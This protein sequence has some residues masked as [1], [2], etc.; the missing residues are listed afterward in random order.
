VISSGCKINLGLQITGRRPDGYHELRTVFYPLDHP[1]DELEFEK[2]AVP[3][4]EIVC[5]DPEIRP[6]KN[7]IF[8]AWQAFGAFCRPNFGIRATLR[9]GIPK[10]A[11]LGGGSGDAAAFLLWLNEAC[12]QPLDAAR[13]NEAALFAGA[14]VPFFLTP[15]PSLASGA[16][17]FTE[18]VR[19]MGEGLFI[20]LVCPPFGVST[21]WAFAR[22]DELREKTSPE[23]CLTNIFDKDKGNS[24]SC[25]ALKNCL[26]DCGLQNDLEAA[27]FP[28]YPELAEIKNALLRL[29]ALAAGMSGSGSSI[30]GIF[31]DEGA[32]KQVK[33]AM[34]NAGRLYFS[35][36]RNYC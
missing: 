19:F 36:M 33:E 5:D 29:G 8:R 3:G 11:G 13:L 28:R 17:E 22:Y 26:A 6:E 18:P 14:D 12:G 27:V 24:L 1:R 23:N 35:A 16:G 4:L 25:A 31:A 2:L 15:R 7:T 21:A 9:K 34:R 30:F 32:G 10:E 20:L